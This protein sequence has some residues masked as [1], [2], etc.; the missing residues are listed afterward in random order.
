MIGKVFLQHSNL[1]LGTALAGVVLIYLFFF[2][3]LDQNYGPYYGDEFFYVKNA[4]SFF[5]HSSLEAAFTYSGQ[6]AKVFGSDAHGPAY[7]LLYGGISKVLGWHPLLLP[8]INFLFLSVAILILA[9]SSS[10]EGTIKLQQ[11]LLI[12]ACPVTLFYSLTF[13][14]ELINIAGGVGIYLLVNRYLRTFSKLDFMVLI[15]GILILGI[16]RSTWFFALFGFLV[17]PGPLKGIKKGIFLLFPFL[18]PFLMQ[19]FL[20]EQVPNAYSQTG[21]LIDG[22]Q[23]RRAI[24]ALLF[25]IKRNLYFFL[26]YTEGWFYTLQKVWLVCSFGLA[27]FFVRKEPLLRFGLAVLL[28]LLAF[29][30]IFYKNYDWVDLRMY[31]PWL[32]FLNLSLISTK[33]NGSSLL[34]GLNSLTFLLILPLLHQ[35]MYFRTHPEVIDLPTSV[36]NTLQQS[37]T[38]ILVHLDRE[39]LDTYALNQLP[40][41]TQNGKSIRYILPHY[42]MEVVAPSIWLKVQEGQLRACPKNSLCQ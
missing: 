7:P 3:F 28:P 37:E 11:I 16:L 21:E 30:F 39:I 42:E 10:L 35:V 19:H 2:S 36:V 40:V 27:T 17:I 13:L 15:G 12:L 6:G 34:L 18:L 8:L 5:Q 26:T 33:K 29:N 14:P 4:E 23:W 22:D 1:I 20:H 32:I 41:S 25:N 9:T 24:E 38:P 31:T